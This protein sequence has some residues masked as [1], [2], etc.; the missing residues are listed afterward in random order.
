MRDAQASPTEIEPPG[1]RIRGIQLPY[2]PDGINHC[3]GCGK[4]S[5]IIGR[6][7]AE[8]S[9]CTTALAM[10]HS[11]MLGVGT[12]ARKHHVDRRPRA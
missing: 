12:F 11:G 5:W 6:F 8:C 10:A 4:T 9:F 7:S 3:P 2:W 1:S